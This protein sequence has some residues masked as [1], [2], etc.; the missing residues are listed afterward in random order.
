MGQLPQRGGVERGRLD[1]AEPNPARRPRISAAAFSVNVTM[2]IRFGSAA[3]VCAA[4]AARW[5]MTRVLP[6]PAPARMT[7][8]PLVSVT[9]SRC[10]SFRVSRRGSGMNPR[11]IPERAWRLSVA[12]RLADR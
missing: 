5:L 7:S 9:A 3:F 2:S 8:G 1:G 10:S 11:Y 12:G 6:V 4:Y